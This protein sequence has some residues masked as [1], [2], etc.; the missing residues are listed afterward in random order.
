MT[1][2]GRTL[3]FSKLNGTLPLLSQYFAPGPV[4]YVAGLDGEPLKNLDQGRKTQ[5]ELFFF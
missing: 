4:S 5:D 3:Y 2:K 1:K